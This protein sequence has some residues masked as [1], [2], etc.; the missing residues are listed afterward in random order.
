[1]LR[2]RAVSVKSRAL[3]VS[4]CRQPRALARLI[5]H[6]TATAGREGPR[7]VAK[8]PPLTTVSRPFPL[9]RD[10]IAA[11]RFRRRKA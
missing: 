3:N 7:R 4:R 1:M 9:A 8:R 2:S 10:R 6:R 11:F 5:W